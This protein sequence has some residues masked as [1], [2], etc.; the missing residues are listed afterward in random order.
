MRNKLKTW[1]KR[2]PPAG[3]AVV[4]LSLCALIGIAAFYISA[5]GGHLLGMK[6]LSRAR[7]VSGYVSEASFTLTETAAR[8]FRF[9][10]FDERNSRI[11]IYRK[12]KTDKNG[13]LLENIRLVPD[14]CRAECGAAEC[15]MDECD[16]GGCDVSECCAE[17]YDND[18][19][20][21]LPNGEWKCAQLS[22]AGAMFR[23]ELSAKGGKG[24]Y[25]YDF[26]YKNGIVTLSGFSGNTVIRLYSGV[27]IMDESGKP[28]AGGLQIGWHTI[29]NATSISFMEEG[30]FYTGQAENRKNELD[31]PFLTRFSLTPAPGKD[32]AFGA[33]KYLTAVDVTCKSGSAKI[34]L[35]D[36][37]AVTVNNADILKARSGGGDIM[38]SLFKQMVYS[39]VSRLSSAVSALIWLVIRFYLEKRLK[40]A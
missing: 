9:G 14:E 38:P 27:Q 8:T 13:L 2:L 23:L 29:E 25:T 11:R 4:F 39:P 24:G 12:G 15:G 40:K 22:T 28:M 19:E 17:E 34:T 21:L 20:K 16:A 3:R 36:S 5:W 26:G 33:V 10:S 7:R 30:V 32:I 18:G 35:G 37:P 1:F 31:A 6:S